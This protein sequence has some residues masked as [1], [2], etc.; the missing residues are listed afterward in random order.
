LCVRAWQVF[1]A[2]W[3]RWRGAKGG[4][5]GRK[6]RRRLRG[7]ADA[8]LR[9]HTSVAF[10]CWRRQ[11]LVGHIVQVSEQQKTALQQTEALRRQLAVPPAT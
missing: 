7:I 2:A 6:E 1:A 3:A 9:R 8:H 4:P 11:Q 5:E 10:G